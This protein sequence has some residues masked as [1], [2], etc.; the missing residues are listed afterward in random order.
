ML[1]SQ[2]Y[3]AC[4][5]IK[6]LRTQAFKYG[7]HNPRKKHGYFVKT[8]DDGISQ[9]RDIHATRPGLS[10]LFKNAPKEAVILNPSSTFICHEG[11]ENRS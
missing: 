1:L 6:P 9:S 11:Q 7:S 4:I 3:S 10:A 8:A 2:N 5:L